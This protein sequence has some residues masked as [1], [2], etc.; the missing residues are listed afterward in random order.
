MIAGRFADLPAHRPKVVVVPNEEQECLKDKHPKSGSYQ[1]VKEA[2][3]L[4][5]V[6]KNTVIDAR[7]VLSSNDPKTIAAV[8][9]GAVSV[10]RAA[11]E[12]REARPVPVKAAPKPVAYY[13]RESH[14][15]NLIDHASRFREQP[16]PNASSWRP[17][18]RRWLG[19]S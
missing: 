8:D 17:A 11:W 3:D 4:L 19:W 13:L 10:S 18:W 12:I 7:T 6:G 16:L 9:S 2:S 5:N 15:L 1:T 14:F